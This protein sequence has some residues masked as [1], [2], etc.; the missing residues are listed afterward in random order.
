MMTMYEHLRAVRLVYEKITSPVCKKYGLKHCEMDILMYLVK[1]P[2]QA[3][4]TDIVK[5]EN[6]SKSQVSMSLRVLESKGYV[7]GEH[8]G[9]DR[10]TIYLRVNEC[11]SELI[12]D[13]ERA[14]KVFGESIT[15]GFS[16]EE[17]QTLFS[18]LRRIKANVLA[19]S[20]KI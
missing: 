2:S 9:N 19:H 4:A 7:T 14:H 6:M 5:R 12:D 13:M 8:I 3:T 10:R 1:H 11:A 15:D 17:L 20:K 16:E 18:M